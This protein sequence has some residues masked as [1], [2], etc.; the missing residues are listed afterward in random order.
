MIVRKLIVSDGRSEREV[1]LIGTIV[2]GRDPSCQLNDLDPLLSRRHAEFVSSSQGVTIRDLKSRNGILVNGEKVPE[3]VLKPGDQIQLGH[4]HLR[5]IEERVVKTPE[6]HSRSHAKTDTDIETPTMAPVERPA[7]KAPAIPAAS[8]PTE[9]MPKSD[10]EADAETTIAPV[11]RAAAAPARP[12]VANRPVDDFDA[13]RAPIPKAAPPAA[14]RRPV[15]D[16]DATRAPSLKTPAPAAAARRPVDD[17]DATR[18]SAPSVKTPV[19]AVQDFDDT[20]VP[21]RAAPAAAPTA[22]SPDE[23]RAPVGR[24]QAAAATATRAVAPKEARVVA[25]ANLVV[26]EASPS[27][28]AIIG[29]RPETIVGGQLADAISRGLSFVARGDGPP[30]LSLSIARAASGK[31]ITITFRAGQASEN[32]S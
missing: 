4:L 29:A 20:Q 19:V 7:K 8:A 5:Y 27:C 28:H 3:H 12:P 9:K 1:L 14:A 26:T 10:A 32:P 23:T 18:V 30:Q 13:T 31:T 22:D 24:P 6:D 21:V 17:P 2:V 15:D 25:N 16:P 11:V